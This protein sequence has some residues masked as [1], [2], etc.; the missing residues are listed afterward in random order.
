MSV[1]RWSEDE[2]TEEHSARTEEKPTQTA[3]PLSE[4]TGETA[5]PDT[6]EP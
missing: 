4:T 1:P 6:K 3:A 5:A 2:W